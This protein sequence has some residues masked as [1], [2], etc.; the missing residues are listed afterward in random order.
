MSKLRILQITDLCHLFSIVV[1]L[2]FSLNLTDSS[3]TKNR[4]IFHFTSWRNCF[5]SST[6]LS[7]SPSP[8]CSPYQE[9]TPGPQLQRPPPAFPESLAA[10]LILFQPRSPSDIPLIHC[11]S[12][13]HPIAEASSIGSDH[14]QQP[15]PLEGVLLNLL[16]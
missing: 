2:G 4:D 15:S 11:P 8:W 1:P 13:T 10:H 6:A 7:R 5:L 9:Q 3:G 14:Q 16:G 12:R